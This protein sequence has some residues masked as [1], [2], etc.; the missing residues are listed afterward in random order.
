MDTYDPGQ[1][2][3]NHCRRLQYQAYSS[4][5]VLAMYSTLRVKDESDDILIVSRGAGGNM[6]S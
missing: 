4:L 1:L 2:N 5:R 3:T 6:T